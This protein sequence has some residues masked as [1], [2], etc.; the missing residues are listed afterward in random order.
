MKDYADQ[1]RRLLNDIANYMTRNKELTRK[2]EEEEEKRRIELERAQIEEEERRVREEEERAIQLAIQLSMAELRPPQD[3]EETEGAETVQESDIIAIEE[4]PEAAPEVS[5]PPEVVIRTEEEEGDGDKKPRANRQLS[6]DFNQIALQGKA[7]M[8]ESPAF[9][10]A[11]EL[12]VMTPPPDQCMNDIETVAAIAASLQNIPGGFPPSPMMSSDGRP[13]L[14]TVPEYPC[15]DIVT[16]PSEMAP[17][18]SLAPPTNTVP[19]LSPSAKRKFHITRVRE[20]PDKQEQQG[21]LQAPD[22]TAIGD[23]VSV[24]PNSDSDTSPDGTSVGDQAS[25]VQDSDSSPDVTAIIDQVSV[26]QN[27]GS[28]TSPDGVNVADQ[29]SVAQDTDTTIGDQALVVQNSDPSPGGVGDGVTKTDSIVDDSRF[30][31]P[32]GDTDMVSDSPE[33]AVSTEQVEVELSNTGSCDIDNGNTCETPNTN[34]SNQSA[35]HNS[36]LAN[37]SR[38]NNSNS[39]SVVSTE[40]ND[41]SCGGHHGNSPQGLDFHSTLS[42]NGMKTELATAVM[43]SIDKELQDFELDLENIPDQAATGKWCPSYILCI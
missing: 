19:L 14:A 25:V 15:P 24:V 13:V 29:V 3:T 2:R 22:V 41:V 26:V 28:D 12:P 38:D 5:S 8:L 33:E 31:P 7:Q 40:S 18:A 27:S 9:V 34:V 4:E 30:T 36:D 37:H 1:Q 43:D 32:G 23:Q 17:C 39:E 35:S 10:T 20:S 42:M 6:L 11:A 16:N 21:S